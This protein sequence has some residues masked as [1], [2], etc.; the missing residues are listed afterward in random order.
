MK[1]DANKLTA[2]GDTMDSDFA[3]GC[4]LVCDKILTIKVVVKSMT[5]VTSRQTYAAAIKS[6]HA[7]DYF[8]RVL[9]PGR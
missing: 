8:R 6:S 9:L 2:I 5:A 4:V 7:F 1:K 3:S